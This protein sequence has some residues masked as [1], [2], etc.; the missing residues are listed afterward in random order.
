MEPYFLGQWVNKLSSTLEATS[1]FHAQAVWPE[2]IV[3]LMTP[4]TLQ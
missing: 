3:V 2:T 4:N 1:K